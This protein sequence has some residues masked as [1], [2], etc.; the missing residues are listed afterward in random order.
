MS[1]NGGASFN[2]GH[3]NIRI[4][5]PTSLPL[6][7]LDPSALHNVRSSH[8]FTSR[9]SHT[10]DEGYHR[11]TIATSCLQAL[12]QFL[13]LPD[14]DIL[15]S[16]AIWVTHVCGFDDLREWCCKW[17]KWKNKARRGKEEDRVLTFCGVV[18]VL[19]LV[20]GFSFKFCDAAAGWIKRVSVTVQV[21]APCEINVC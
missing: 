14:L 4:L 3:K 9:V 13:H 15:L 17:R 19:V 18:V 6:S 12:D 7:R 1:D 10:N 11:C 5:L 8:S 2:E 20:T 16:L 21:L